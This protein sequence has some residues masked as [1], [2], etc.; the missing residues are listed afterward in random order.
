MPEYSIRE[1][2][3]IVHGNL[4]GDADFQVAH[5]L[6]DSRKILDPGS[7]L[8]VALNGEKRDG[9]HFIPEALL[10][11]VRGFLV[12]QIPPGLLQ[13]DLSS[14][15]DQIVFVVVKDTLSAL[16]Q[17]AA[18][19]RAQFNYPVIGLTGSNGK[20]IVKEWLNYLMQDELRIIRSPKSYNSQVGVPLSVWQMHQATDVAIFEAGISTKGE[21]E[22]LEKMIR[23]DIG[24]FTNIGE[25]HNEGFSSRREKIREKL[26]LFVNSKWLIYCRDYSD[27]HEEVQ[28]FAKVHSVELLDWSNHGEGSFQVIDKEQHHSSTFIRIRY[29]QKE[30]CFS[31]PF[32]A[33]APV[34]NAITCA[35]TMF[36][37]GLENKLKEKMEML[38]SLSMR[39]EMKNGINR[40]T[41]INDSYSTDISSLKLA[42]DFLQQQQQ[43]SRRTVILSDIPQSGK[44]ED[45]LYR[46]VITMLSQHRITSL[47]GV[48]PVIS[49]YA[50]DFR[51]AGIDAEFWLTTEDFVHHFN[52]LT[53][54]DETIL[55]KGARSFG[56]EQVNQLLEMKVH[57]TVLTVDLKAL[58]ENVALYRK[59]L[60]RGTK[61]MVMVKAFSYGSGSYEIANLM[62]FHKVDYLAVAYADEGVE[63][64]KAGISVPIMVMNPDRSSFSSLVN[65]DL[66][67]EIFSFD[68]LGQF[69]DFLQQEGINE[70]PVHIK[71]DTGMHRLGFESEETDKLGQI[72]LEKQRL[73]V[74]TVFTHL[75]GSEDP[76]DDDYTSLQATR[77]RKACDD[78][79][80]A[81]R[82][83]FTR[84]ISNTAAILRH[85]SL[86]MDM[87]R[88]GIG[89][90]GVNVA[91][92][93][94]LNLKN[95]ASLTTTIAQIRPVKAGETVGYNRKG[96]LSRDSLI[97]TI[98]IGYA[99]GYPRS[100]GN[101]QG[102]VMIRNRLFP[103]V[104]SVCMDM[105]MVDIT[106]GPEVGLNDE[107]VIFGRGLDLVN[108]AEWAGT[109]TYD[110]MTG[111]SQRVRRVYVED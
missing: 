37:L 9:H 6:T 69:S 106:D 92:H 46:E 61:I 36:H 12:T 102:K 91:A 85:P 26:S 63:L 24:I 18:H 90:Y 87:V 23:P 41:V 72:L 3:S 5:I 71:L 75:A 88:L 98:R 108:V 7:S 66:Q 89:L 45:E 54:K 44:Q 78:L 109:I 34:E 100:L 86:Q 110:I 19:H 101:G 42:L 83:H 77:F 99:D 73:R 107:V 104:G 96:R 11:G 30:V 76:A 97:A 51:K 81:L 65:Y 4:S 53:Y 50:G 17:L 80:K 67:P 29:H 79:E 43:H 64:R 22:K 2:S 74:I 57:Q 95:V 20:T 16:H 52:P 84:H 111:I 48:G 56:F 15:S 25:A 14:G 13:Q 10:R 68:I 1:I 27:L 31:I 33:A 40:C 58:S 82:Y 28:L 47:K 49:S 55:I 32:T 94:P 105:T 8:F 39:L 93:H 21:M 35:V 103:V 59:M 62:Q 38:P 70:F 60:N